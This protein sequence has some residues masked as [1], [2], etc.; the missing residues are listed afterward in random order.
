MKTEMPIH[1]DSQDLDVDSF[2]APLW[3]RLFD[4]WFRIPDALFDRIEHRFPWTS[5]ITHASQSQLLLGVA[6]MVGRPAPGAPHQGDRRHGGSTMRA[7]SAGLLEGRSVVG[8]LRRSAHPR[9]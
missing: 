5:P 8:Y 9:N 4:L 6:W 3:L 1:D 2:E 7:G